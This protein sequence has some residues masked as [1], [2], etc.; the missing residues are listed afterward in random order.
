MNK[1]LNASYWSVP[2]EYH[3]SLICTT[4]RWAEYYYCPHIISKGPEVQERLY[5]LPKVIQLAR[6]QSSNSN[7]GNTSKF[8]F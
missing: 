2:F 8:K 6:P 4:T 1:A 7:S 3:I 5:V